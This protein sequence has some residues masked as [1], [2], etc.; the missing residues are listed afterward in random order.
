MEITQRV[1]PALIFGDF[2]TESLS[3]KL[4]LTYFSNFEIA[5]AEAAFFKISVSPSLGHY[6]LN[7]HATYTV[8]TSSSF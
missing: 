4:F 7:K 8:V 6:A 2:C 3:Q 5:K 1:I